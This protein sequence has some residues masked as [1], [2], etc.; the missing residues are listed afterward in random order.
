MWQQLR[1][2]IRPL[3]T[4]SSP[5]LWITQDGIDL[6]HRLSRI[7][8]WCVPPALIAIKILDRHYEYPDTSWSRVFFSGF[9]GKID[10]ISF[11]VM[12]AGVL[13]IVQLTAAAKRLG[14]YGSLDSADLTTGEIRFT[15]WMTLLTITLYIL[16]MFLTGGTFFTKLPPG[17]RPAQVLEGVLNVVLIAVFQ[18][19]CLAARAT[20]RRFEAKMS[21]QSVMPIQESLVDCAA[22]ILN[23]PMTILIALCAGFFF[24][25][26][27]K[28]LGDVAYKRWN[29]G[30]LN[31]TMFRPEPWNEI[32]GGL[33][34]ATGVIIFMFWPLIP[35]FLRTRSRTK[36]H[37]KIKVDVFFLL[38]LVVLQTGVIATIILVLRELGSGKPVHRIVQVER[39]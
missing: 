29:F 2:W 15:L 11:W 31:W 8:L 28:F 7:C 3:A 14:P 9:F 21:A 5:S 13:S 16:A 18:V 30:W 33:W 1:N 4:P 37:C 20:I 6:L 26:L 27:V 10:D 23:A 39:M 32:R 25:P 22:L 36:A 17:Q 34:A 12:V 38:L 24:F 19:F 35:L